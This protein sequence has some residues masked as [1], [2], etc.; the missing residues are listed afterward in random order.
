[1]SG[2]RVLL[3]GASGLI[4][5]RAIEP[6]LAAGYQVHALAR[7]TGA[8]AIAAPAGDSAASAADFAAV[9]WHEVD[10]LDE[11]ASAAAVR[12]IAAEH[13]LHLAWCT[14]HGRFWDAPEN[15]DWVAAS[16]R[17]LRNFADAGGRRAVLAGTCA[18]YDWAAA[19]EACL[20]LER[21]GRP[22]T[23]EAPA[24]LYGTCKRAT[25]LVAEAYARE[26]ALSLAW[27]RVFL[28]YGPG[29]DERRLVPGV[30]RALLSSSE[31]PT[32]DGA[33]I[34][35]FM[36]VD[37]VAAGFVALLAGSVEGPVNIA[38]G[39]GVPIADVL[40]LIARAAGH[41]ELLRLGA[42]PRRDGE[43]DRLVADIARLRHEVGFRPAISLEQGIA[44]TV[45]SLRAG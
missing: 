38:S 11:R 24:T 40:A 9:T 12:E 1:M 17:L 3:T 26:A 15:L 18:E 21:D 14:E 2:S 19:G 37:D 5:S 43:P 20:E 36:H 41:P 13:L 27:G 30:A 34:R 32:S 6:L 16:L 29:E 39:D 10:L 44:G 23:P 42:L 8:A 22:A 25:R 28:L 4:G 33:Q 45:E 7:R 35:D 31:A